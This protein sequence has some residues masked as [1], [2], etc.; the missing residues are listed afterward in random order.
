MFTKSNCFEPDPRVQWQKATNTL[1]YKKKAS[2]SALQY[3]LADLGPYLQHCK[4]SECKRKNQRPT[5]WDFFLPPSFLLF[6]R[7]FVLPSSHFCFKFSGGSFS[8]SCW[9]NSLFISFY[10]FEFS[11]CSSSGNLLAG[12]ERTCSQKCSFWLAK[13]IKFL[14]FGVAPNLHLPHL[15]QTQIYI[16]CTFTPDPNLHSPDLHKPMSAHI[17]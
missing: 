15:H 10:L 4:G 16:D 17:F 13:T 14:R 2:L 1:V 7:I 6:W 5:H 12:N 3:P 11:E 9:L 8:F